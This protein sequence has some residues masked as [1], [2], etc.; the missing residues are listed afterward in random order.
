[1]R[2]KSWFKNI[3]FLVAWVFLINSLM[4]SLVQASVNSFSQS[5]YL[6]DS[7]SENATK[8]L[9]CTALGYKWIEISELENEDQTQPIKRH[10]ECP[11]CYSASHAH[12]LLI[13]DAE[14]RLP[15]PTFIQ[16]VNYRLQL[17]SKQKQNHFLLTTSKRGPPLFT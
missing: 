3:S 11:L 16:K 6:S 12:T 5:S 15:L 9:I 13:P 10:F 7:P 17:Q 2:T 14:I 1:M 8:I 4:P